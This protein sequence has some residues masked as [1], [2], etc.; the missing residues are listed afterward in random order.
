MCLVSCQSGDRSGRVDL[1]AL[2]AEG[3]Q[4]VLGALDPEVAAD[5]E[6]AAHVLARRILPG[7]ALAL[8]S[9]I[10]LL[11]MS[12][13]QRCTIVPKIHSTTGKLC[14]KRT[15]VYPHEPAAS[16]CCIPL[17]CAGPTHRPAYRPQHPARCVHLPLQ[18]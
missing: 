15:F 3:L 2:A 8:S 1:L 13:L 6:A 11:K 16:A 12:C 14:L 10:K 18:V 4:G 5:V 9:Y 7:C 17:Q